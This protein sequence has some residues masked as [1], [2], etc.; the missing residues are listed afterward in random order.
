M[1]DTP[2]KNLSFLPDIYC[3]RLYEEAA[4]VLTLTDDALAISVDVSSD[5]RLGRGLELYKRIKTTAQLDHHPTN[6]GFAMINVIDD[7][8]PATAILVY[9]LFEE[10]G[11]PLQRGGGNL[12]LYRP[13]DRHG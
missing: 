1:D 9:R 10:F 5:D 12:P 8:A 6:P 11:L 13:C 4:K 2:P 3:V 7:T